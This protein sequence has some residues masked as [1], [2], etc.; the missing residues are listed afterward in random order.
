MQ[1][2]YTLALKVLQAERNTMLPVEF[3]Q[4]YKKAFFETDGPSRR[5]TKQAL[6]IVDPRIGHE[7]WR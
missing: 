2:K 4:K 5:T 7:W 6:A 3:E 1:D